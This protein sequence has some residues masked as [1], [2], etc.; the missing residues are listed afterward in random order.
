MNKQTAS[1]PKS[2]K[3][4]TLITIFMAFLILLVGARLVTWS[5]APSRVLVV[6]NSP[7]P[8]EP[9][10][11]KDGEAVAL[12]IDFCKLTNAW[13]QTEVN[14]VGDMGAKIAVAWP[15]DKTE[16]GCAFYPKVPVPIPA[17]TPTDTYKVTFEVCYDVNPLKTNKCT[18]FESQKFKVINDKLS[19]GD[20]KVI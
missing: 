1:T 20:A 15:V 17:Q 8:V 9:P 3:A 4:V 14:L 13:G 2:I 11:V 16:K 18:Y 7:T 5:F 19:P 12:S 6:K 10:E